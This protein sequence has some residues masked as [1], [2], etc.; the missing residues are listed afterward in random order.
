MTPD[1]CGS[2]S[3]EMFSAHERLHG[4]AVEQAMLV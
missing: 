2:E 1:G 3:S 4:D